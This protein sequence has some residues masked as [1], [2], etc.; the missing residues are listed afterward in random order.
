MLGD[1]DS[2]ETGHGTGVLAKVA[3]WKHGAAK[4]SNSVVVR[5]ADK[6]QPQAWLLGIEVSFRQDDGN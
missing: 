3:G 1:S 5:V 6:Y 4:R 2:S